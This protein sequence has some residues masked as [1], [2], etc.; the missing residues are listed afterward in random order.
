MYWDDEES[1][2]T[3]TAGHVFT[4]PRKLWLNMIIKAKDPLFDNSF[5]NH[6]DDEI[7]VQRILHDA[8]MTRRGGPLRHVQINRHCF[9]R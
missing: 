6:V 2:K 9:G 7:L 1:S 4:L 8:K 3:I 5:G